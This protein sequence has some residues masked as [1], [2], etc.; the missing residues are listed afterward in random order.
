MKEL[1]DFGI[2]VKLGLLRKNMTVSALAEEIGVN[3]SHLSQI[4]YGYTKGTRHIDSIK[5]ILEI[6]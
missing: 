3:Q 1:T 6:S 5:E 2:K 4:L